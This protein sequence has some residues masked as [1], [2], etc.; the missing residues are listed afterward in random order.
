MLMMSRFKQGR[1]ATGNQGTKIVKRE[2]RDHTASYNHNVFRVA[3][4]DCASKSIS[5]SIYS[6]GPLANLTANCH[7]SI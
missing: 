6:S 2:R 4:E 7:I 5:A 3:V 1:T